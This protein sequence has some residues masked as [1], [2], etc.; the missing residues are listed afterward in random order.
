ML[1]L[2]VAARARAA[3]ADRPAYSPFVLQVDRIRQLSPHFR[4]VTFTGD[5]L[6]FWGVG[7]HDQRIKILFP[8]DGGRFG[9]GLAD[10]GGVDGSATW[11]ERWSALPA[12]DQNPFRTYTVRG[13]R[14]ESLELDVD[15]V[16]HRDAAD[17]D[18]AELA[19][20]ADAA[21]LGPAGRWLATARPGDR[22]M[23]VGPDARSGAEPSGIDWHPGDATHALLAGDETAVPAICAILESL[24]AGFA[25]T[26][27]LEVPSADDVLPVAVGEQVAVTWLP[28]RDAPVGARLEQAVRGWLAGQPEH[29]QPARAAVAQPLPEIDVDHE[30]L[31]DCA[32]R[33]EDRGFYAWL[34][35]ESAAIRSLRRC[36]VTE[37]GIDRKQVAFMGYWRLGRSERQ[38]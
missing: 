30:I 17:R 2:P 34:A 16:D 37:H 6:Q 7:G 10:D 28:R 18:P 22:V 1:T 5:D 12:Q 29:W 3:V 24:P 4:R 35:G 15:F 19:D 38:R 14:A 8:L 27:F 21:P 26:V 11:H 33:S 9:A 23:V 31:W 20:P 25:A 36:L 32:D 13:F